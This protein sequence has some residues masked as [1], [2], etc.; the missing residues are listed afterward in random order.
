MTRH[1]RHEALEKIIM[2]KLD[3]ASTSSTTSAA[4]SAGKPKSAGLSKA[5]GG[6]ASGTEAALK[7]KNLKGIHEDDGANDERDA[8]EQLPMD[9]Q[10]MKLILA[11]MG[12]E[13]HD[14]RVVSQLQEF[15]HRTS[16]CFDYL[17]ACL[18]ALA[19]TLACSQSPHVLLCRR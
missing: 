18:L 19:P 11:S 13:R 17:T 5:N 16:I 14:P 2:G 15:V 4:A 9:A 10:V 7:L 6:V 1:A 8:A 3:G 12:A